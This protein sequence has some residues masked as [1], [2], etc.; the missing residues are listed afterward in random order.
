[1]IS[2]PLSRLMPLGIAPAAVVARGAVELSEL[3][4]IALV[5][6]LVAKLAPDQRGRLLARLDTIHRRQGESRRDG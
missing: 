5:V 3:D 4:T 2:I 1:M 6:E